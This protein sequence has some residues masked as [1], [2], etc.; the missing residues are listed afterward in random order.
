MSRK[1]IYLEAGW[2]LNITCS[3]PAMVMVMSDNGYS[4]YS[5]QKGAE[6]LGGYYNAWP[7]VI[8]VPDSQYWNVLLEARSFPLLRLDFSISIIKPAFE[9]ATLSPYE[10]KVRALTSRSE[11][12][13]GTLAL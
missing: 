1:R 12:V 6:F 3:L 8:E 9:F 11:S 4:S 2:L 13:P 5:L 7:A 10:T